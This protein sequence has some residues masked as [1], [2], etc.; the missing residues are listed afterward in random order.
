MELIS[1]AQVE[2]NRI[3]LQEH[4][5]LEV[6]PLVPPALQERGQIPVILVL[7]LYAPKVSGAMGL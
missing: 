3:V 7:H 4:H 2:C 1:I 5:P 6:L